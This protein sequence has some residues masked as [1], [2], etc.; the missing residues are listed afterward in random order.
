MKAEGGIK[1]AAQFRLQQNFWKSE[2]DCRTAPANPIVG[3]SERLEHI[4]DISPRYF[5]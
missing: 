4:M 1:R 5:K 2:I 3:R